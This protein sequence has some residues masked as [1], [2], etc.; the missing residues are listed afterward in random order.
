[1]FIFVLLR[2]R[3]NCFKNIFNFV[4]RKR[5]FSWP[6]FLCSHFW[7]DDAIYS[8]FNFIFKRLFL[9]FCFH[10]VKE[11][12]VGQSCYFECSSCILGLC[13]CQLQH[14]VYNF[15][16]SYAALNDVTT[17]E[18]VSSQVVTKPF[19]FQNKTRSEQSKMCFDC[20]FWSK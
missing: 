19:L 20:L 7:V 1:M 12:T 8:L 13:L 15:V 3:E 5:D 2:F 16:R 18:S 4:S 17:K 11:W 6:H 14:P 10:L 9:N